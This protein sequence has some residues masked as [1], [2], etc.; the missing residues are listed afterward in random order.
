[1]TA[2]STTLICWHA[3]RAGVEVLR[4][5]ILNLRVHH[6]VVID[7]VV[8]LDQQV[9]PSDRAISIDDVEIERVPV[10]LKDPTRHRDIYTTA[11]DLVRRHLSGPVH[12]NVSPGTPAM[13]AVWLTLY[14]V[15]AL[16]PGTRLWS[17]QKLPDGTTRIDAVDFSLSTYLGE[18]RRA[19]AAAPTTAQYDLEA[20]SPA[21]RAALERLAVYARL[22]GAPL[23]VLGE[24]GTGKSR[25][26]E[27]VVG[28]LKQRPVTVVPC[29]ALDSSLADS[30]LFGHEKGAFTG[31]VGKRAG[32]LQKSDKGV[33]FLD[34]VQDLPPTTQRRLVRFLQDQ[35]GRFRPLGAD[36]EIEVDVELVCASNLSLAALRAR[37]DH[38]LFDRIG[39][40]IVEIPPLRSCRED[41]EEDW[42]RVWRELCR[43]D[44]L[45]SNA[46]ITSELRKLLAT[47]SLP[48]NLRDLQRL[49][50]LIAAWSR[51]TEP[52]EA[53]ATA[54]EEWSRHDIGPPASSVA[55]GQG[56]R[57]VRTRWFQRELARW[58]KG[59]HGSWA[60]AAK[61]LGCDETTLR[62]DAQRG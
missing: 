19:H 38:D 27:S 20:R 50:Y 31:A 57:T 37:L 18:I 40:L 8:L 12:V 6:R 1:M 33:L 5:A 4:N 25:L 51:R 24:R 62:K 30:L 39:H 26:V 41:L 35:R 53:V 47:H 22:R 54:L 43:D 14:A 49:A 34:E 42:Q 17:S 23:L 11:R 7:R 60:Q 32:L 45:A 58:A 55:F 59:E 21:R 36:K 28:K 48:G 56:T 16:P 52:E 3:H 15:G 61:A 13:H 10:E 9:D 29:G 46:P 44:D 2:A